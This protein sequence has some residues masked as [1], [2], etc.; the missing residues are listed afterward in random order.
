M[1]DVAKIMG[2][3]VSDINRIMGLYMPWGEIIGGNR[4]VFGGGSIGT[5]DNV[6]DYVSISTP[7]DATD[8]GDLTVGREWT[9]ATSNGIND[10]G[11]FAG[12]ADGSARYNV[13][14]YISISVPG[15]AANFGD[16]VENR[17]YLASTSNGNNR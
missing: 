6:M 4:A 15:N 16:L 2:R 14:D 10:T 1:V 13:I 3:N 8:F 7:G 9:S 11:V 17:E 12:G 5:Y